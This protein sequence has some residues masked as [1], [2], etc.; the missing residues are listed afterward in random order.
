MIGQMVF[1]NRRLEGSGRAGAAPLQLPELACDLAADPDGRGLLPAARAM[2]TSWCCR[3]FVRP[4][5][6]ASTT[7]SSRRWRWCRSSTTRWRRPPRIASASIM[8]PATASGC[9][10]ISRM[11]SNG[12]SG[13][14]WRSTALLLAFGKPLLW[15]FG[16][17]FTSGYPAMFV[18]AI[19]LI[20]RSAIGPVERLLNMLGHQ[21]LCALAYALA[22]VINLVLCILLVPRY[23]IY[24]AASLHL[25]R[26]G[27]RDRSCC[28]G[29]PATVSASM[30]SPSARARTRQTSACR[31][32]WSGLTGLT[33]PSGLGTHCVST[34]QKRQSSP[35]VTR[36][37]DSL[38][39]GSH[40]S[41]LPK[42]IMDYSSSIPP[43]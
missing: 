36:I 32:S 5:T 10:P 26:A 43:R 9:R 4:T 23:G 3:R 28:S 25:D 19:G 37:L 22:F 8:W 18:V 15:L 6:S 38:S 21:N 24:G 35:G 29:S 34:E 13:R 2:S 14:R 30:S 40:I 1:L 27:V 16:A 42:Y 33:R 7:P 11:R 41:L 17:Q 31:L 39:T 12:R 20:A